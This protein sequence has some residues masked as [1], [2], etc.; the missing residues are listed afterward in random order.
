MPSSCLIHFHNF[1]GVFGSGQIVSGVAEL[2]TFKEKSV[3]AIYITVEGFAKVKWENRYSSEESGSSSRRGREQYLSSSTY[4]V[5]GN[6]SVT[7][8]APAIYSYNFKFLLPHHLPS[9]FEGKHGHIRYQIK[10]TI[11]R[12][13]KFDNVFERSFVVLSTIDL[14]LYS[15][16]KIPRNFEDETFYCSCLYFCNFLIAKVEIPHSGYVPGQKIPITVFIDNQTGTNCPEVRVTLQKSE[17]YTSQEPEKDTK[18]ITSNLGT[19]LIGAAPKRSRMLLE[20]SLALPKLLPSSFGRC[21]IIDISYC[22][23]ISINS[24][25]FH[26]KM[27]MTVPIV[28]GTVPLVGSNASSKIYSTVELAKTTASSGNNKY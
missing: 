18:I 14:N 9:S 8:L 10:L 5:G 13:W 12:P 20:G 26:R 7:K 2:T 25:G 28:V 4:V 24:F 23:I 3:R 21:S 15:E 19:V 11:D 16:L 1:D 17:K 22:L 27:K 6:G